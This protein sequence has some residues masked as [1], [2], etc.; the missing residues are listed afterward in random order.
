M[1]VLRISKRVA[2]FRG[3]W[4]PSSARVMATY[5]RLASDAMLLR[6]PRGSRSEDSRLQERARLR[7]A[8]QQRAEKTVY[9]IAAL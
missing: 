2:T 3:S 9:L 8:A 5:S 7:G 4:T 6:V 1:V